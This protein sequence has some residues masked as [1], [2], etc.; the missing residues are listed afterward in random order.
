MK[1]SICALF[2]R[3]REFASPEPEKIVKKKTENNMTKNE[4]QMHQ[5]FTKQE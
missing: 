2:N 5:K 1:A 4:S 3:G